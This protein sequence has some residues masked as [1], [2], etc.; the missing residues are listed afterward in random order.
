MVFRERIIIK[1]NLGGGIIELRGVVSFNV[2]MV[3]GGL[4]CKSYYV[5]IYYFCGV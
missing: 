4:G 1:K 2:L 5:C 3:F